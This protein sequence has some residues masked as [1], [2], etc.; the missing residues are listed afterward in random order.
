MQDLDLAKYTPDEQEI[1]REGI[2]IASKIDWDK[3]RDYWQ[4][5]VLLDITYNQKHSENMPKRQEELLSESA[6]Q[7]VRGMKVISNFKRAFALFL[8][9]FLFLFASISL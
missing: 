9:G 7:M 3:L 5:E 1:L 2:N 6:E 4:N 8:L